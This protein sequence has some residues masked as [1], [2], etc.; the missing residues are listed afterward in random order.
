MMTNRYI[1]KMALRMPNVND[2]CTGKVVK[3][4]Q[5]LDKRL[6][7]DIQTERWGV[8]EQ[9]VSI[10]RKP[11]KGSPLWKILTALGEPCRD[12]GDHWLGLTCTLL[13]VAGTRQFG[14]QWVV[15]AVGGGD[16]DVS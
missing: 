11:P 14:P 1:D 3:V 13:A 5:V 8:I 10:V 12:P 15:S 9:Q 4:G 16:N 6:R 2:V 7:L